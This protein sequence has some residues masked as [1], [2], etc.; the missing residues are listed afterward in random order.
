MA[1]NRLWGM[2]IIICGGLHDHQLRVH[3]GC[4][5]RI[6]TA[7]VLFDSQR[8]A[9]HMTDLALRHQHVSTHRYAIKADPALVE[10]DY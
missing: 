5:L 9:F 3:Y 2:Y 10:L 7:S 4:L 8:W 1:G 6:F